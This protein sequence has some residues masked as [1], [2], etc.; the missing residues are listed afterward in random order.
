MFR[1]YGAIDEN[2]EKKIVIF[3]SD[4]GL[5]DLRKAHTVA[6]DCTFKVSITVF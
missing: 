4:R 1:Y 3:A 6:V 5:I 2:S